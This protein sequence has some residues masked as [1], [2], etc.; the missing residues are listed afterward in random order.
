MKNN[1]SKTRSRLKADEVPL[2]E[3]IETIRKKER[4]ITIALNAI[5]VIVCIAIIVLILNLLN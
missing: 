1:P 5:I 4:I 3:D 2:N